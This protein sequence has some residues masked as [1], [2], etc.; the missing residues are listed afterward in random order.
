MC[1]CGTACM[2]ITIVCLLAFYLTTPLS[3]IPTP[4][5]TDDLL[6]LLGMLRSLVFELSV[7]IALADNQ[8]IH[9][10]NNRQ[11]N[12]SETL[13]NTQSNETLHKLQL[14]SSI[15]AV[16]QTLAQSMLVIASLRRYPTHNRHVTE[17]PGRGSFAC[18]IIGNVAIWVLRT[19]VAKGVDMTTPFGYYGEVAWLLLMNINYPLLLF[20]RFHSSVCFAG[21][22][23]V[24]Y[25]SLDGKIREWISI[26]YS[27]LKLC[28]LFP[29]GSC[30]QRKVAFTLTLW[31]CIVERSCIIIIINT[32]IHELR[33][34]YY[35]I[36]RIDSCR[37]TFN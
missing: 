28:N 25:T 32:D 29:R 12:Q 11:V 10:L 33:Y 15:L 3:F 23:H 24:A 31:L 27:L 21:V 1:R 37:I 20:F 26:L 4:V 36:F 13:I 19:A 34:Q 35:S 18:L 2:S 5:A 22:W 14:A 30:F 9:G 6:L 16:L 8:S 7:I 17:M